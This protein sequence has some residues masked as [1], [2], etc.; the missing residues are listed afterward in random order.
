[1]QRP[2]AVAQGAVD[3]EEERTRREEHGRQELII[4]ASQRSA[5]WSTLDPGSRRC[6]PIPA[7]GWG[8]NQGPDA[9]GTGRAR[10]CAP[11]VAGCAGTGGRVLPEWVAESTGIRTP[12]ATP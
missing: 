7:G 4:P 8:P 2:R 11:I 9:S 1:P 12:G 5:R 10:R 6:A 3:Q